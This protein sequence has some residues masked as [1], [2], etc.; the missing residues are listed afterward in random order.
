MN[1]KGRCFV[2]SIERERERDGVFNERRWCDDNNNNYK[3]GRY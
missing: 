1:D 3:N 2:S